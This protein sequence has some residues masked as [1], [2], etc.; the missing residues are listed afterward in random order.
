MEPFR[1]SR[2]D[3]VRRAVHVSH[4]AMQQVHSD[5]WLVARDHEN[6]FARYLLEQR[7]EAGQRPGVLELVV[8]DAHVADATRR[9][10][11][12]T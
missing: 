9:R 11:A 7:V 5:E 8:Y 2:H 6:P 12:V 10:L 1:R 4:H 3:G